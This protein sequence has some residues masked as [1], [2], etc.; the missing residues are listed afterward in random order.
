MEEDRRKL[1]MNFNPRPPRGGRPYQHTRSTHTGQISIHALREEGDRRTAYALSPLSRFQSTPSARRATL[2][3]IILY[4][5]FSISIHAL[6][7]EGDYPLFSPPFVC[8]NFNP[9]PPRGGRPQGSSTF[10]TGEIFQ[11]TPSAR[12]ATLGWENGEGFPHI[13]IHALREES[14]AG[15]SLQRKTGKR[16]QSTP[17]ARRA[18][19]PL[20]NRYRHTKKFQSTPS[21]RRA[22]IQNRSFRVGQKISIHALREE[23]DAICASRWISPCRFQSTPSARRATADA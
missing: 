13:S 6:R 11:S 1:M 16:F 7:E 18:T 5:F 21:A 23:S 22:T 4:H 19:R 14:D 17:S 12:R 3:L 9:R 2:P 8:H 15:G 20:Y 10:T